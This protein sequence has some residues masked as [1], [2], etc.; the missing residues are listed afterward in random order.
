MSKLALKKP[1]TAKPLLPLFARKATPPPSTGGGATTPCA[2]DSW[3]ADDEGSPPPSTASQGHAPAAGEVGAPPAALHP[4]ARQQ[5]QAAGAASGVRQSSSPPH[6]T[7]HQGKENSPDRAAAMEWGATTQTPSELYSEGDSGSDFDIVLDGLE[8]GE[9]CELQL[10]CTTAP[11]AAVAAVPSSRGP[12]GAQPTR[13]RACPQRPQ[14]GQLQPNSRTRQQQQQQEQQV[15][16]QQQNAQLDLGSVHTEACQAD[17]QGTAT[18]EQCPLCCADLC[19]LPLS[20]C[21]RHIN[22]CCDS[23]AA[24]VLNPEPISLLGAGSSQQLM[25]QEQQRWGPAPSLRPAA[26]AAA[27]APKPPQQQQHLQEAEST[28]SHGQASTSAPASG[29]RQQH[30]LLPA[31]PERLQKRQHRRQQEVHIEKQQHGGAQERQPQPQEGQQACKVCGMDLGGMHYLQ[32]VTHVKSCM[33]GRRAP[34]GAMA[35][36]PAQ[37]RAPNPR[38][39]QGLQ[40]QPLSL[41][42]QQADQAGPGAAAAAAGAAAAEGGPQEVGIREWLQVSWRLKRNVCVLLAGDVGSLGSWCGDAPPACTPRAARLHNSNLDLRCCRSRCHPPPGPGPCPPATHPHLPPVPTRLPP[43]CR[44]W[45][46]RLT[47][48]PLRRRRWTSRWCT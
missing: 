35:P 17:Q 22:D 43:P 19:G 13:V 2:T 39:Q 29:R 33:A 8:V 31:G 7:A 10:P 5:Q 3:S 23:H 18:T 24:P 32:A 28:A 27:A 42:E 41:Q 36:G 47:S 1:A 9:G 6:P 11:A 40:Q 46:W 4:P 14:P 38:P 48:R 15:R 45:G 30:Q 16:N 26:A 44:A 21:Q 34:R 12:A 20:A 25:Q 37:A